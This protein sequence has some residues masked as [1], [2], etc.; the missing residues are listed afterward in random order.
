[1]QQNVIVKKIYTDVI[2]P[3]NCF[4]CG[5][6]EGLTDNLFKMDNSS[7][8][9]L[10]KLVRK[11]IPADIPQLEK[12]LLACPGRGF[13]YQFLSKKIK[14]IKKNKFLGNYNNLYIGSSTSKTIRNKSSSGGIVRT[15]LIE[16]IKSNK[17]DYA[18]FLDENKNLIL[19][20]N[21]LIT[22]KIEDI[23][24]SSQSVY[25][26]TAILNKLKTLKKNK[27]YAFVGL[28]EHIASLRVLKIYFPEEFKHIKYLISIYSG[29]NMYP[30]AVEFFLKG[31]G[32][33]NL[34]EVKKIYWRYGEWPGL[35]RVETENK[36]I[37]SLKKFYYNYLIPFFI[38]KNCLITPD[39]TGE[40]SD[41]S[42]GD[43]WS[44]V[45]EKSGHG[46]SIIISR[47]ITFDKILNELKQKEIIDLEENDENS[48]IEM[49]S[50]M[51]E[52]KK[53]GSYLRIKKLSKKG[54]VPLYDL[55]PAS[56][57]FQR[58]LIETIIGLI[59][60]LAASKKTKNIFSLVS[61]NVLG[62][63]FEILRKLWKSI[64]KP[65]KR[66]GFLNQNFIEVKNDRLKEFM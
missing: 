47:S 9:P 36:K 57:S 45:L 53:I 51:L 41:I 33:K 5:L 27:S 40:L 23:L 10:P 16:L 8:G 6:C 44:P 2:N 38:S 50:H 59:I 18:C 42:I 1:M 64:T 62:F 49:H 61:S 24:N 14:A 11:P 52:F 65:T 37:L 7:D 13:P 63:I 12:I 46:Y 19:D 29:T 17:I 58:K 43:A 20:F 39:F 54:P 30:G 26:T 55:K 15:L 21:L 35:L 60:N 66:K 31:N 56:I 4:H 28:P 32:V 22:S 3:G 34:D 25:Q 48:T